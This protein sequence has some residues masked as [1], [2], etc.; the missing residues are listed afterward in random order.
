[1]AILCEWDS[2]PVPCSMAQLAEHPTADS[3]VAFLNPAQPHHFFG[4]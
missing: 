1:M 3:E 2:I 4:V